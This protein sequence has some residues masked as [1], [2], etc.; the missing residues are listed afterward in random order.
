MKT[1]SCGEV[2]NLIYSVVFWPKYGEGVDID[3]S[4]IQN[5]SY[6]NCTIISV[7][8][9]K[10][11]Q[12]WCVYPR[13]RNMEYEVHLYN[14]FRFVEIGTILAFISKHSLV[15]HILEDMDTCKPDSRTSNVWKIAFWPSGCPQFLL[16][17]VR[18][19]WFSIII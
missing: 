12:R 19:D 5:V 1:M 9:A 17:I 4:A 3:G 11:A 7:A 10:S 16:E 2:S 13:Y 15:A 18:L 6:T 8:S 14:V